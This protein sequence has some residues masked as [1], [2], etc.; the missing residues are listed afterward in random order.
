MMHAHWYTQNP[1]PC[2][3]HYRQSRAPPGAARSRSC[4]HTPSTQSND[5]AA[6]TSVMRSPSA[7]TSDEKSTWPGE[8]IRLMR[9]VARPAQHRS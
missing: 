5:D 3:V 2:T 8:S 7:V 4:T 1:A 6:R 9:Y